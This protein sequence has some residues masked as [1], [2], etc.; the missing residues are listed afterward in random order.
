MQSNR[1]SG[2]TLRGSGVWLSDLAR[3][4]APGQ[5]EALEVG[6]VAR[7]ERPEGPAHIGLLCGH[8]PIGQVASLRGQVERVG[9]PVVGRGAPLHQAGI[10]HAVEKARDVAFR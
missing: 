9:A 3:A 1:T 8:A 5:N 10:D 6:K 4:L 7:V 2:L